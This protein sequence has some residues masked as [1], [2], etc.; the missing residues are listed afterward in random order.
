MNAFALLVSA[1]LA[2][3]VSSTVPAKGQLQFKNGPTA[4]IDGDNVRI[5]FEVN[6]ATDAAVEVLD[7]DARVIR[8]LAWGR[9][10]WPM[11]PLPAPERWT[12]GT[13]AWR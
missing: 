13:R 4:G 5:E 11:A 12:R 3:S 8:H 1:L 9:S 10:S 6:Q 7:Q 2:P